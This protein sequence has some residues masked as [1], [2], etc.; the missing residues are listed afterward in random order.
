MFTSIESIQVADASLVC[1]LVE[2]NAKP[3]RAVWWAYY[4]PSI[5]ANG[6]EPFDQPSRAYMPYRF[7]DFF[8]VNLANGGAF[9]MMKKLHR[10]VMSLRPHADCKTFR[11]TSK[12]AGVAYLRA[13]FEPFVDMDAWEAMHRL[14]CMSEMN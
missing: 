6:W 10:S 13:Q 14:A 7:A 11:V 12:E 5:L 9:F 1:L 8:R 4:G 3:R 2:G